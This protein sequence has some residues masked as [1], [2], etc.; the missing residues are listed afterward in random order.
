MNHYGLMFLKNH[1]N[2]KK[3]KNHLFHLHLKYLKLLMFL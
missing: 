2:Q 1:L 3:L